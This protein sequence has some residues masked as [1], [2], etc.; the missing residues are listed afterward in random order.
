MRRQEGEFDSN[1]E[2]TEVDNNLLQNITK[3]MG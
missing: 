1:E 3:K 2:D